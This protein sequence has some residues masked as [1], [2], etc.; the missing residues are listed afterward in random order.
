LLQLHLKNP[1]KMACKAYKELSKNKA[2][3]DQMLK[4]FV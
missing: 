1:P 3:F 4:R 2:K